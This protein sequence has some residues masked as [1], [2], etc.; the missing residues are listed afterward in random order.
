[1]GVGGGRAYE[2]SSSSSSHDSQS[3]GDEF[4]QESDWQLAICRPP[5]QPFIIQRLDRALATAG[6]VHLSPRHGT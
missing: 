3:R 2:R 4:W 1:M 6:Q 5:G